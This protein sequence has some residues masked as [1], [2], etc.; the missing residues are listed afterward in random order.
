LTRRRRVCVSRR[1][2]G[3]FREIEH[4]AEACAIELI[5]EVRLCLQRLA[6][7]LHGRVG[8]IVLKKSLR[9]QLTRAAE[10]IVLN[11]VEGSPKPTAADKA[12]FYAIAF[13]SVREVQ[14]IFRLIQLVDP[15]ALDLVDHLAACVYRLTYRKG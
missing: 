5:F 8:G 3:T 14:A 12:R 10:S 4:D 7:Q 9:E 2:A 11:L 1:L 13:G 6:V 15:V